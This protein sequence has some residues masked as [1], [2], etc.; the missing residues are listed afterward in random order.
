M[1]FAHKEP[2]VRRKGVLLVIMHACTRNIMYVCMS[3]SFCC[4]CCPA[5]ANKTTRELPCPKRP[6]SAVL[7]ERALAPRLLYSGPNLCSSNL[8][9]FLACLY[10]TDRCLD[11]YSRTH[12]CP[13]KAA[14]SQPAVHH[15]ET[16]TERENKEASATPAMGRPRNARELTTN[17]TFAK[18]HLLPCL[19]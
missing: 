6:T 1:R 14:P 17:H 11:K 12:P 18:N 9:P 3:P 19:R 15:V 4:L 8:F 13:F 10:P 2:F 7:D 16:C 5:P